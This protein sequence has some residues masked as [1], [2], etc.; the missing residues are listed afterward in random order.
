MRVTVYVHRE[1]IFQNIVDDLGARESGS[2]GFGSIHVEFSGESGTDVGGLTRDLFT[3]FGQELGAWGSEETPMKRLF[4]T[5]GAANRYQ[6]EPCAIDVHGVAEARRLYRTCGRL[7]AIAIR[8]RHL[9]DFSLAGFFWKRV[10][11][12]PT[13]LEESLS[14]L[15]RE[16]EGVFARSMRQGATDRGFRGLT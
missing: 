7:C 1:H 5:A 9:V 15:E 14:D 10:L 12:Q 3:L 13:D 16:G 4:R 11:L 8:T 2:V 6:P